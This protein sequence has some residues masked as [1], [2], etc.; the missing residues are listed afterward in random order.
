MRS[1]LVSPAARCRAAMRTVGCCR[2]APPCWPSRAP[3][4]SPGRGQPIAHSALPVRAARSSPRKRCWVTVVKRQ[5]KTA[6]AQMHASSSSWS[7]WPC[8]ASGQQPALALPRSCVLRSRTRAAAP[9]S[10]AL[11]LSGA[12]ARAP[13]SGSSHGR[14]ASELCAAR[15]AAALARLRS[16]QPGGGGIMWPRLRT[17]CSGMMPLPCNPRPLRRLCL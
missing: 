13:A 8:D 16:C 12:Q 9:S 15:V 1:Y 3:R 11:Q 14:R 6:G 2:V 7:R 4:D 17:E 5:T 10:R